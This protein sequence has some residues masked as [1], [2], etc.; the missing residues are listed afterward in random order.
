MSEAEQKET[1]AICLDFVTLEVEARIDCCKHIYCFTCIKEWVETSTNCCPLCKAKVKKIFT[2]DTLGRDVETTVEEKN[3]NDEE[4]L[5]DFTNEVCCECNRDI[6]EAEFDQFDALI[7]HRCLE[8]LNDDAPA[9]HVA[10]M[11]D[12][13]FEKFDY[14]G[15]SVE[16]LCRECEEAVAVPER[17][18][19]IAEQEDNLPM[20]RLL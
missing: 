11:S 3:L 18:I 16:W 5:M 20:K 12:A 19:E 6:L 10:C 9:I 8:R 2:R 4:E 13:D 14:V 15:I 17:Q 1:C 7:C